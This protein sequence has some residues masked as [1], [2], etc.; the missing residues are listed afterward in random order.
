MINIIVVTHGEFGAYMVEAAESIAGRQ[1]AG[2]R[3]ISISPRVGAGEA[4]ERVKKAV[5]DLAGGDGL[6]VFTDMPGGTPNN[7]AFPA[8]K[9]L[10]KVEVISGV[11]LYMLISAFINRGAYGL[12]E[13]IR[14][15]IADGQKSICS[16]REMFL[17]RTK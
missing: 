9:D 6:I 16:V 17:A 4:R 13:L 7:L 14:K 3:T 11:N 12:E 2:V 10:T 8:T 15:V 1:E 5:K